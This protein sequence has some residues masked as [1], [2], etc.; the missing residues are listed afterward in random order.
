MKV[1]EVLFENLAQDLKDSAFPVSIQYGERFCVST[2][3]TK[4]ELFAA[5]A[6]QGILV[7]LDV[8]SASPVA[9]AAQAIAMTDALLESLK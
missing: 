1:D 8:V 9:I 5:M 4:R 3:V 6:L 2:G 7:N